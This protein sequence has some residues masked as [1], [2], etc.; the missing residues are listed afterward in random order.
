MCLES[1]YEG[2]WG[3][4]PQ[5]SSLAKAEGTLHRVTA[6]PRLLQGRGLSPSI[7]STAGAAV[8]VPG[9]R[10]SPA[11]LPPSSAAP[12]HFATSSNQV[13][14]EEEDMP[15]EQSDQCSEP[16]ISP[17]PV[18]PGLPLPFSRAMP[19][20][21][22]SSC[23]LSPCQEHR[24]L[25]ALLPLPSLPQYSLAST[26]HGTDQV[27]GESPPGTSG[28]SIT[29]KLLDA[30]EPLLLLWRASGGGQFSCDPEEIPTPMDK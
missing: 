27:P 18:S 2:A 22:P 15:E 29:Q 13:A 20:C 7:N 1:C 21:S 8:C 17:H 3:S 25:P 14:G 9:Y 11:L 19:V 6:Q 10:G 4:C 12:Q 23:P 26:A 30:Q 5:T 16:F 28:T 24:Q